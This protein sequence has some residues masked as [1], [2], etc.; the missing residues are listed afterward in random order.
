[1]SN[2][3]PVIESEAIAEYLEYTTPTP[4]EQKITERIAAAIRDKEDDSEII[5][6]ITRQ[7][8][9]D[10]QKVCL[11]FWAG[12]FKTSADAEAQWDSASEFSLSGVRKP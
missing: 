1:M 5:S 2:Q 8:V 12:T 3:I 7:D 4:L 11:I 10:I 6:Y 9:S